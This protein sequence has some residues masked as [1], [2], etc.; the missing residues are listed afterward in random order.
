[1][2]SKKEPDTHSLKSPKVLPP[3]YLGATIALTLHPT[4]RS[5][6]GLIVSCIA[7]FV[8]IWMEKGI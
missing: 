1:M 7:L 4:R 8:A 5:R 6:K 3:V 2:Q